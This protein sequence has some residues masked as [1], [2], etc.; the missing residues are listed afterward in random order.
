MLFEVPVDGRISS[1]Y[2]MRKDPLSGRMKFHAGID[3]A[4][5]RFARVHAAAKGIVNFSGWA[6]GCGMTIVID[7]GFGIQT[8]YCHLNSAIA[9]AGEKV[10]A[11]QT[12]AKMGQTGRATGLHLH[13]EVIENGRP[14]DPAKRLAIVGDLE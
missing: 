4:N 2:G 1:I 10:E 13:F 8:K 6:K 5:K 7:H 9:I 11:G 14:S 3:F 12:I